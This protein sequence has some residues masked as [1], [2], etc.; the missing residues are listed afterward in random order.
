MN[1]N[2]NLIKGRVAET[3][4]QQLFLELGFHVFN[5]GMEYAS[6]Q[7]LGKV[8]DKNS[9][10]ALQIR[11]MPDFVIQDPKG[12]LYY[13]EVK[14]RGN[15]KFNR[16]SLNKD[17]PYKNALFVI[18]SKEKIQCLSFQDLDSGLEINPSTNYELYN[19]KEFSTVDK[20]IVKRYLNYCIKFFQGVS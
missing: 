18:V 13:L 9:P 16:K 4:I 20:T 17:F 14:Y 8:N 2:Y 10:T 11:N 7:M 19:R 12:E 3:I 6:P 5:Y 15:G 1:F